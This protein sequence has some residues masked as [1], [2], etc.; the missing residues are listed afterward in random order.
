MH[1]GNDGLIPVAAHIEPLGDAG[2]GGRR[3]A[4]L[5]DNGRVGE[6]V[7]EHLGCAEAVA[8][9][10]YLSLG[11]EIAQKTLRLVSGLEG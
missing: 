10:D 8:E 5:F 3:K 4:C 1:S 11:K 2:H 6:L 9:F 7:G